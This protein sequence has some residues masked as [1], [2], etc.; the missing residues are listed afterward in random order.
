[1]EII[2][3]FAITITSILLGY[4]LGRQSINGET[5]Q[6]IEK[7]VKNKLNPIKPGIIY[8][9]TQKD[10]LEKKDPYYKKIKE[11]KTEM[12]KLLDKFFKKNG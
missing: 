1:M 5:F 6:K 2:S 11:E 4:I 12:K 3:T 9:P 10:L 8:R 7:Q